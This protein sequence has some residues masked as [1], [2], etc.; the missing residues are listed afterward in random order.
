MGKGA[1]EGM[2]WREIEV[3]RDGKGI[4][5]RKKCEG[6]KGYKCF[7]F[8]ENRRRRARGRGRGVSWWR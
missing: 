8:F 1:G 7:F 4:I 6:G 3:E 2:G 5:E